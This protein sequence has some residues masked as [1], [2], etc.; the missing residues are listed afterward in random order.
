MLK[1][2]INSR[3][4]LLH[5]TLTKFQI[6]RALNESGTHMKKCFM[7]NMIKK[8]KV[9]NTRR[10]VTTVLKKRELN[11]NKIKYLK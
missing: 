5:E 1:I 4:Y 11:D 2:T 6:S 8:K 10:L 7:W 3:K 9:S